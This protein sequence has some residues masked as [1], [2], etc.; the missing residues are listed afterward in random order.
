MVLCRGCNTEIQS[1]SFTKHKK[2][3]KGWKAANEAILSARNARDHAREAELREQ[4]DAAAA[5]AEEPIVD[6]VSTFETSSHFP[7]SLIKVV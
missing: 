6:E 1:G 7:T 3:C 2:S 5:S 4:D